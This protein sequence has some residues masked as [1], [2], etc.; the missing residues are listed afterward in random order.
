MNFKI[1]KMMLLLSALGVGVLPTLWADNA[2]SVK[3]FTSHH[4]ANRS[5][6]SVKIPTLFE[7]RAVREAVL[8]CARCQGGCAEMRLLS[9]QYF[10]F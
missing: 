7:I 6:F 5:E 1:R 2:S 4:F 9:G 8:K 10:H 3:R